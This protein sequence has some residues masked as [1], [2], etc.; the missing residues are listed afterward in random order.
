MKKALANPTTGFY[1]QMVKR[2]H[3]VPRKNGKT[4]NTM[5]T[6]AVKKSTSKYNAQQEAAIREAAP[7]NQAKAETLAASFGSGFTGKSVIAKAIRMGVA[8]ERKQPT[9]KSGAK[10]EKKETLVAEIAKLVEGN[11]D[12]LE[13][14]PKPALQAIRDFLVG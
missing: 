11:L 9:T 8:Y 5:A 7:L 2:E 4:T 6:A 10:I 14:A 3:G 12:G 1:I 13:K